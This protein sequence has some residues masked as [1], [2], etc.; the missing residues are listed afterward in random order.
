MQATE[1]QRHISLDDVKP[2]VWRR[3]LVPIAWNLEQLHLV[4]QAAFNWKN[5]HSYVFLMGGL[6]FGDKAVLE[7]F[8]SLGSPQFFENRSVVLLDFVGHGVNTV[9]E[10]LPERHL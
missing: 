6:R 10:L 4:I 7:E 2:K 8:A 9:E 5:C 3:V 1:V